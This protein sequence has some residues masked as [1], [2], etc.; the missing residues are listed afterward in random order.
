M[1]GLRRPL[2]VIQ[3]LLKSVGYT[4]SS[5]ECIGNRDRY[6]VVYASGRLAMYSEM[7][8]GEPVLIVNSSDVGERSIY[9]EADKFGL[10]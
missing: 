5:Y 1:N 8:H 3:K 6:I 10:L 4:Y 9:F 2:K 7:M